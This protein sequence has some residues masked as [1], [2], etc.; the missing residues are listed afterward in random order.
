TIVGSISE[1]RLNPNGFDFEGIVVS[2]SVGNLYIGKSY[3]STISDYSV[4]LNTELSLLVKGR[5][6]LTVDGK[7]LGKVRQVNR[8]GTTNE[9]ESLIVGS[10]W[11]KYLLPVSTV[12]QIASSVLIK[13]KYNETKEYLWTRPKQNT[14]I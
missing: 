10:F 3:F 12:K 5:K 7:V 11:K 8:R 1:V 6:V 9:I 13:P 14:N 4:I 2:S